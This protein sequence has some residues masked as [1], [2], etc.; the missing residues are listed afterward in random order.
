MEIRRSLCFRGTTHLSTAVSPAALTTSVGFGLSGLYK[1]HKFSVDSGGSDR[2]Q[3][4]RPAPASSSFTLHLYFLKCSSDFPKLKP[5]FL[6]K[7][8]HFHPGCV[9][10]DHFTSRQKKTT[11][12]IADLIGKHG[13]PGS[14]YVSCH[15]R[16]LRASW[17]FQN[18][19][20]PKMGTAHAFHFPATV[21]NPTLGS[22]WF[23]RPRL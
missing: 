9:S 19:V 18:H 22:C 21:L 5:V 3:G 14:T 15:A 12:V 17:L 7:L 1:K 11:S 20:I 4:G 23:Q 6:S 2:Q 8:F 13:S 10:C 16:M